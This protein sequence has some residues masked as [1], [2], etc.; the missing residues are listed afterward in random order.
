M[1]YALRALILVLLPG[2][3]AATAAARPAQAAG[4]VALVF[5]PG[6]ASE[7]AGAEALLRERVPDLPAAQ[8][9]VAAGELPVPTSPPLHALGADPG[10]TCP[11]GK[12]AP[13]WLGVIAQ[14][15]RSLDSLDYEQTIATVAAAIEVLTCDRQVVPPDVAGK[16]FMLRGLAFFFLNDTEQARASF[17]AAISLHRYIQ[18]DNNYPPDPRQ[19]FLDAR[20]DALRAGTARVQV[21]AA[22]GE[23]AQF[24]VDG[25]AVD[26]A[27]PAPSVELLSGYH[28]VQYRMSDGSFHAAMT[29]IGGGETRLLVSR[30]GAGE[31]VLSGARKDALVYAARAI[32]SW[33][34]RA[35]GVEELH[36]VDRTETE[37]YLYRFSLAGGRFDRLAAPEVATGEGTS[38]QGSARTYVEGLLILPNTLIEGAPPE[39]VLSAEGTRL[40]GAV[41]LYVGDKLA[42]SFARDGT[43]ATF[44]PPAGL[45]PAVY[46]VRIVYAD[47]KDYVAPLALSVQPD[48]SKTPPPSVDVQYIP[49]E[50]VIK[51][52]RL[53]VS[54]KWSYV[55]FHE[56]WLDVALDVNIRMGGGFCLDF[57]LGA[58]ADPEGEEDP[59]AYWWGGFKARWYPRIVQT[60][61]GLDFLM[62]LGYGDPG[63][64]SLGPRGL[65]GV[66]IIIPQLSAFFFNVEA[67][68]GVLWDPTSGGD[69]WLWLNLGGGVGVRF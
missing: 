7:A 6:S 11:E 33:L 45:A 31:A 63:K 39:T 52:D 67:G 2:L 47:G 57:G 43:R 61:L 3:L 46:D 54:T 28:L 50:M 68:L 55:N 64:G 9:R 48:P 42:P 4:G 18:W 22:P 59:R 38:G 40:D 41:R 23:V 10:T 35:W 5:G 58:Y 29:V 53:R 17:R 1:R 34:C 65:L 60:Y 37:P 44:S 56:G 69:P 25:A 51:A 13:E 32:D 12:R 15:Q 20:E 30:A 16:L 14:A 66:D 49:V 27:Q 26:L 62:V 24:V 8:R 19:S 36:V 21:V